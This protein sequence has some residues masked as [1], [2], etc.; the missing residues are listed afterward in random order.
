MSPVV[1]AICFSGKTKQADLSGAACLANWLALPCVEL[2][3][4][5]TPIGSQRQP[6]VHPVHISEVAFQQSSKDL[7]M[8]SFILAHL[9]NGVMNGIVVKLL[10][11]RR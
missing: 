8:T 3:C 4:S 1:F 6:F 11:L 5:W 9:M 7:P 2:L 10:G